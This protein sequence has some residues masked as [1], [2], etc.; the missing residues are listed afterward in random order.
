MEQEWFEMRDIRRRK[1][2]SAVWIPLRANDRIENI[3]KVGHLGN[4]SD[5][6]G[7]G[8]LAVPTESK[9]EIHKLGWSDIGNI[10]NHCGFVE[11]GKYIP[12]DVDEG[13]RAKY[14]G[15]HLVL[16]QRGN[17]AEQSEWHLHQDFVIT[18]GLKREGDS[19]IRPDEGY[20]EV[21]RLS[22]SDKGAP[23]LLEVRASHLKDYL[24]ARGM[25]LYVT[26]YRDRSEVVEDVKHISWS[27][28]P[29][30]ETDAGD[31]W[32]G[33]IVEIHEGGMAFGSETA[34]FHIARTD[35]DPLEDVPILGL[36]TDDNLKTESWTKKDSGRKLYRVQGEL[37]RN[38]WID[39]AST[40]PIVRGDEIPPTVFFIVDSEGNQ[41]TKKTLA[42]GG[43]WLWFRPEVMSTLAHRR[44]GYLTWYTR[45]TGNVACSPDYGVHFG[46]NVLGLINVYAKDIAFLPDWQQ[47]IWA[48]HNV[49][50]EGKVSGELL[51]SQVNAEPAR[52]QAPEEFLSKGLD[53]LNEASKANLGFAILRQHDQIPDL[54]VRAHRFRATDRVGLFSLAKDLA[55]LTAD[56][57][58]VNAIKKFMNIPKDTKWGS[59]KSLENLLALRIEESSAR[60]IV[61]PLVGIYKLRLADAHLPSNEMDD[62]LALAGVDQKEPYVT[63]GYQLLNACV[64]SIFSIHKVITDWKKKDIKT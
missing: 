36:P 30:V 62:S 25:G 57:F 22:K 46:V 18:L 32:E 59:L 47:K 3:G 16:D 41:E 14:T 37:W 9:A 54:I 29:H 17:R 6:F 28:N 49:G 43:R 38:E 24:C 7:V 27:Q 19:W 44:G 48:G 39:P 31:S 40:S 50:P 64:N 53:A 21:A 45:N 63:Q 23:R 35:I 42:T 15:L 34:V 58:D 4:R 26:S 56:S 52:T 8:T 12:S 55:R 5:F 1:L 11:R 2:A 13:Y 20:I 60:E 33:R 51:M 61:G 10:H